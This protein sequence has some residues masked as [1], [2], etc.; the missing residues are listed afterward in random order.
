MIFKTIGIIFLESKLST[1]ESIVFVFSLLH[2]YALPQWFETFNA[3]DEG[4]HSYESEV[5]LDAV[6]TKAESKGDDLQLVQ[7]VRVCSYCMHCHLTELCILHRDL[8]SLQAPRN[9]INLSKKRRL[10]RWT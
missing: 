3:A 1:L 10:N 4:K 6:D 9:L 5:D 8:P 7:K 2:N